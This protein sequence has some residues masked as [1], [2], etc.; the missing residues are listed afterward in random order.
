VIS[1]QSYVTSYGYNSA[2]QLTQMTYPGGL[3]IYY[4]YD[5]VGRLAGIAQ[6]SSN[7]STNILADSFLYQPATDQ[8][9][10]WRFGNSLNRQITLDQ[11]SRVQQL[12]SPGVHNLSYGFDAVDSLTQITDN[13]YGLSSNF[14]YDVN[15]RLTSVTKSG[16]N[17]TLGVDAAD[18]RTS[19]ARAGDSSTYTLSS[20]SN[21]LVSS[22]GASWRNFG[23]D[24]IGNLSSESR[25]D[26]SRSYG[27][28][29]FNRLSSVTVNGSLAGQ[30]LSNALNQRVMKTTAQGSTRYV[31]GPGG[32]LLQEIG[33]LTTT[34]YI[35]GGAGLLGIVRNGAFY[36]SH[37]DHLGR[38]EVVT[39]ASA[40][41]VWRANNAAFDRTIQVDTIGGLN[42]GFPGQYFDPESG[43]YYNWN[44]YYD[45]QI[46]RYIQSDPIGLSGG[47]NTYAYVAGNP[48]SSVDP[49][50]LASSSGNGGGSGC[51]CKSFAKRTWDRYR[52]TSKTIDQA[53]DSVLPWPIN[54]A[55][56]LAGAAGGGAAAKSYDGITA[57]QEGMRLFGQ[58]RSNS[59]SLFR[60]VA[61]PDVVRVGMTSATTAAV[62]WAAWNGGLLLGSALSEAISGDGCE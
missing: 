38:P 34:S 27:Y 60:S 51:G 50:G 16:D 24:T 13:V 18:N 59:F 45:S 44:R 10:A 37:N 56:G 49:A 47:V 3:A 12:Q 29:A 46:G 55:T 14:G 11:D 5:G 20:S 1:G 2:G 58:Y 23:Y 17:Q 26:G 30:Y 8:L 36:A 54:S 22:S 9:Y 32:V 40:Q 28:D 43:L 41:V 15:K 19:L 33:P 52:D 62:V 61:R 21:Q 35:W 31:Y 42:I 57:L 53:I 6:G 4:C 25:W 39:N 48:V 7:C